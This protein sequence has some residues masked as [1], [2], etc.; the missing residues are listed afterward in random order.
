MEQS[1]SPVQADDIKESR[2]RK[3]CSDAERIAMDL[4][5]STCKEVRQ[6]RMKIENSNIYFEDDSVSRF[7]KGEAC[8]LSSHQRPI[9]CP[10]AEFRFETSLPDREYLTRF[11][12]SCTRC[13]KDNTYQL[14]CSYCNEILTGSIAGPGGKIADHVVT[15]RHIVKEALVQH[16]FFLSK[17]RISSE[18]FDMALTYVAKLELWASTIR[19]KRDSEE[20]KELERVLRSLQTMLRNVRTIYLPF[21]TI[22]YYLTAWR[23]GVF[24]FVRPDRLEHSAGVA[25]ERLCPSIAA[26]PGA[27]G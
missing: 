12:V 20:K 8:A 24:L 27:A 6:S 26:C 4:F 9:Y 15:I 3:K 18:Y 10:N 22:L 1:E 13:C 23:A 21:L 16:T 5:K 11:S 25:G 7:F 14:Y 19:F 2:K 17:G